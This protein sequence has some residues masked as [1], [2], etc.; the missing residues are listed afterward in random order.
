MYIVYKETA[1]ATFSRFFRKSLIRIQQAFQNPPT[2]YL[3][4]ILLNVNTEFQA[5]EC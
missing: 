3:K 2:R 5:E 4:K 1:P